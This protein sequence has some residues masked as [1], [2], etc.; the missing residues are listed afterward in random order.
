[1]KKIKIKTKLLMSLSVIIIVFLIS[2]SSLNTISTQAL[3]DPNE[4]QSNIDS[5][6]SFDWKWTTTNVVS[7][8][9]TGVSEFPSLAVDA[10][11]NVHIAWKD[12]TDYAGAG[13]D[14][15]IFY[16]R[17][18]VSTTSWTTTEVVSTESTATS[19][20]PSLAVDAAGNVHIAWYDFTDYA[21]A[22]TD[23][24]IFYKRWDASTTSWTTTEVVSTES[25]GYSYFPSLAV[26]A[27]GNVHIAWRDNTDYAGAGTDLD[28]FY[29]RWDAF[30]TSWTT[31]EVV[32]TES[33]ANSYI[34]SLA[35]D[36]E[37]NVHIAWHDYT[38]YAGAG[39]DLD[40]FY[41]RW[42]PSSNFWTTIEVV[43]TESTGE[44]YITSLAVDVA[45]NVHI[46]WIDNTDYAGAGTDWDIFYKQFAGPPAAPEL[47]F[48]VPNP[49]ELTSVN[50]DWNDVFRTINY[51]VYRSSSYIWSVESLNPIAT[52]STSDYVDTVPSEGF[53]YYVVIAENL[54]GNS[55]HSNCQ[56]VEVVFPDLPDLGAPELAPILPTLTEIDSISLVWDDVDGA[57]EYYVYRSTSYIWSVEGL[58]PIDTVVSNSYV[59]SLPSEDYYF[60]VI[61][62]SDGLRNSTHS[63]CE[64]VEYKL[65]TLHE[66]FI[67]SSLIIVLPLFLFAVT[68]IRKKNSKSN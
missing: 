3:L 21:G 37:G 25:T 43:S 13:I 50:L 11:G 19:Y 34:P 16:K 5:F 59:D 20:D 4:N 6:D 1:M 44:S 27:E 2:S 66:F 41:R 22:G 15:D 62:A 49:N 30:T 39:T 32:S 55:S 60:Y 36:V 14:Y 46:A 18:E 23:L 68:R 33:T 57:T 17:W 45:G 63:N 42:E 51:Y 38:D 40:I 58:S 52:V 65:P 67:I 53:Y 26:D 35:V 24:D 31:T 7:T 9:S 10:E 56:Y 61:V 28:I 48:I 8:G 12:N 47:A 29:R 54:A 64:Y